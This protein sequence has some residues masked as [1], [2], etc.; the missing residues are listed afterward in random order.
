MTVRAMLL[1]GR[2]GIVLSGGNGGTVN[3]IDGVAPYDTQVGIRFNTDGTIETGK[4]VNGAAITWSGAGEWID[5]TSFADSSYSVRFTNFNGA[6]GGD[7]TAESAADDVWI[8]LGTQRIWR[9]RSTVFETISF[10]ADFEVRK[11]A[12]APPVTASSSYTFRVTNEI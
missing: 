2:K 1:A 7:W 9:M 6:G 8:D 4:S 3:Q 10:T 11:T 12:G 5:P